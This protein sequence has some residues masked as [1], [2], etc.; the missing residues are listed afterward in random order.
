MRPFVVSWKG[1]RVVVPGELLIY[2]ML[3]VF[4]HWHF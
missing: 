3:K 1:H 4:N 2:L